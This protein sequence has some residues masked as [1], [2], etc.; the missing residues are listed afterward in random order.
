MRGDTLYRVDIRDWV[1]R[2][3]QWKAIPLLSAVFW[4]A[5]KKA[6]LWAYAVVKAGGDLDFLGI[7]APLWGFVKEWDWVI[8]PAVGIFG[9]W[10]IGRKKPGT[11]PSEKQ[12]SPTI[13]PDVITTTPISV[14]NV[15]RANNAPLILKLGEEILKFHRERREQ[16]STQ[17]SSEWKRSNRVRRSM[18]CLARSQRS[19]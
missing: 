4:G 10:W 18:I 17:R 6:S 13:S 19:N 1:L 11:S 9:L 15:P 14:R 16:Y 2:R 8:V 7:W 12:N 3:K 5:L